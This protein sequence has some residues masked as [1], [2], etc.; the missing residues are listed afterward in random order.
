MKFWNLTAASD[1]AGVEHL[2]VD[3]FG[4]IEPGFFGDGVASS[5]IAAQLGAHPTA[6]T[7]TARINSFGGDLFGGIAIHNLLQS[8]GAKVTSIV[9]G[10]AGSAAS[11]VAMAGKTVMHRGSMLMIHNP[12]TITAGDAADHRQ[13]ADVLDKARN[14]LV[15]IYQAKTGKSPS[16]LKALMDAETWMTAEDAKAAGFADEIATK[17]VKATAA[18]DMVIWNSIAFARSSLPDRK[19]VV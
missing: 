10:I 3:I 4:D 18:G 15:A 7:I 8:H 9:E 12:Q 11:I 2:N 5:E 13:T 1:A 6:A 16:D 19:S 14:S 17:P